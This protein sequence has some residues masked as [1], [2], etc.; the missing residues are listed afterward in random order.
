MNKRVDPP[1]KPKIKN[2]ADTSN[3][4]KCF[5]KEP[6]QDSLEAGDLLTPASNHFTGFTYQ[7]SGVNIHN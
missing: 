6:P 3:F 5:T 4:D 1:F 7:G 2:V